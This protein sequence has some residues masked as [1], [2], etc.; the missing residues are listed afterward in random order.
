MS[1]TEPERPSRRSVPW[2]GAFILSASATLTALSPVPGLSRAEA[3]ASRAASPALSEE[4]LRPLPLRFIGPGNTSGRITS[5]AVPAGDDGKTIYAGT[6]GGGVWKTV[7]RGTTWRPL[8]NDQTFGSIGDVAVAPSDPDVVWVGTGERNSL[9]SQGWGDGV[10][11]STDAGR[12]WS[13]VG[14]EDTR[15]IGRIAVHPRDPGTA[16][17]AAMGHLWGTNPERGVYKTT[18]AGNTWQKVLFVNDTTGFVDLKMDPSNPEVLYAAGWHRIRW[19]GGRMEGAGEGSGI[20]KTADGGRTWTELTDPARANGLPS[21]NLGRIGLAVAPSD[22]SIVYAVIQAAHGAV[23]QGVSPHGGIFR[24]GDSGGSWTRVNDVSAVPDYFYNEIY[25][26]PSDPD[27]VWLNGTFLMLSTDGGRSF[28]RFDLGNVHVDHHALWIDPDDPETMV[29]G[30]D[31]GVHLSYDGGD[32]WQ[33]EI[34]PVE[35]FYEVSVDTTKVPYHVCG[36]LQDNGVWCG[37]SRTR[38]EAGITARD[39]YAVYGGDGFHSA[40]SPDD[41]NIRYAESQYG[42]IGRWNL[43]TGERASIRPT[44]EDAGA[45]SGYEFRWD[46]NAPFIV[47][48]HDPT[49]LYLGG[50]FLFRLTDRGN[51]WEIL[52]PDMT[53]QSR[54]NPEAQ[55]A[56]T[57]YGALHS[58]A[59]SP[60]D[61]DVLWTGSGDGLIWTT[62]DRGRTWLQVTDN[63]PDE[64]PKQCFVSEIE[65]SRHDVSTA[66]VTFDCHR[67]DDYRPYVYRTTDA[68]RS[69]TNLAGDLPDGGA[70][71]VVRQDPVNPDLLFVGTERG[72]YVSNEGGNRWVSLKGGLPVAAVRD[73]DY[74]L[75]ANE[76]VVGTMGR[77]VHILDVAPL[78]ELTPAVL[79]EDAHLMS[80]RPVRLFDRFDTYESFGDDFFRAENPADAAMIAYYLREDQGSDVTLSIRREGEEGVVQTLTGSGRPGLHR[81][82]WNLRAREP[83]PRELGGPTSADELRT[84]LPGT[85][86]VEMR[87]GGVTQ[88]RSFAVERGWIEET[89]GRVR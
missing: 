28:A 56:H 39:W 9:R 81:V 46:W 85:Y 63:L 31:G 65:A 38:E 4:L 8:W 25:V 68:G 5:L 23:N 3:Q 48:Q 70:T 29:L 33:H 16:Y 76:L 88:S 67:R 42:N 78:Q 58:V 13:R 61:A 17:V 35:Q 62:S 82:A 24:S 69:W 40:V 12:T 2:R 45:E 15:E 41:P 84:V 86:T 75:R 1:P 57:S 80:V 51:D 53:R 11:R 83:R 6:A 49:V 74:A 19:G 79:R 64:A 55:P 89:P 21:R 52:G 10:Y 43:A 50:N 87:A 73:M 59:E 27:R 44:A 14:L 66:F 34:I 32:T 18:D 20:Y 72:L 71:Y 54:W 22:P 7:N 37:P 60:L 36:G 30:N 47:S 26:D 77:G